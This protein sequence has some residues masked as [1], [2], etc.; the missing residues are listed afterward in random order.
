MPVGAVMPV[1]PVTPVGA[2]MPVGPV[3]PVVLVGPV[4]PVTPVGLVGP[5]GVPV[6]P[7]GSGGRYGGC[8][9]VPSTLLPD[10]CG[11]G[12]RT[13]LLTNVELK[14]RGVAASKMVS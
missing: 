14:R 13:Y 5:V 4:I 8:R 1:G 3:I 9:T 10:I 12:R 2:V 6:G 11:I 7:V